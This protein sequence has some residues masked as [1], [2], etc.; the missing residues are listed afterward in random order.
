MYEIACLS[1]TVLSARA[2]FILL[3]AEEFA[4]GLL[5]VDELVESVHAIK[6][7]HWDRMPSLDDRTFTSDGGQW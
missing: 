6:C 1:E 4:Q 3:V 2:D 5:T 7:G